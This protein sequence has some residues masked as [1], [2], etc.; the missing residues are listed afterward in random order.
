MLVHVAFNTGSGNFQ[1]VRNMRLSTRAKTSVSENVF[2]AVQGVYLRQ[3]QH[4]FSTDTLD[5]FVGYGLQI[6]NYVCKKIA[7]WKCS[8][9][10]SDQRWNAS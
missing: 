9:N 5:R 3:P 10:A 7:D 6:K 4:P 1:R 8:Q 2:Q